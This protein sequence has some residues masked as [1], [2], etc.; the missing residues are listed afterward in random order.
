MT[1]FVWLRQ[2]EPGSNSAAANRLLD[3]LEHL[4]FVEELAGLRTPDAEALG[5]MCEQLALAHPA[6]LSHP[7]LPSPL[8]SLGQQPVPVAPRLA[9]VP[10]LSSP[11]ALFPVAG[12]DH[13][14]YRSQARPSLS[15]SMRR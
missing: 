1:R 11:A 3:R 12:D 9:V 10:S 6:G 4:Q 8:V 7:G 14:P 5:E 2:F 13:L 15:R